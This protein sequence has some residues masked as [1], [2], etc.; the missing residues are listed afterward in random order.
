MAEPIDKFDLPRKDWY[1]SEGRI[2]KDA[3]IENFNAIEDELLSISQLDVFVAELP[4]FSKISYPDVTLEDNDNKVINL[5][6]F[7]EIT[8]LMNYPIECVFNGTTCERIAW[9]GEDYK[10]HVVE[11]DGTAAK[12]STPFIY[13][14]PNPSDGN[15][16]FA[17][18]NSTTPTGCHFIGFYDN[19]RV[20]TNSTP[21]PMNLNVLEGLSQMST[22]AKTTQTGIMDSKANG[23]QLPWATTNIPN[24]LGW[25][26][27][28][29]KNKGSQTVN[30]T[31]FGQE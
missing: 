6:S 16:V 15:H 9:W 24:A 17:Q 10:Y 22:V 27:Y 14:N 18:A 8:G 4:D 12:A 13:F 26:Y 5:K 31:E 23:G 21:I 3:L 7:L 20:V 29:E 1:D 25:H 28:Q 19:G 30:L 2:Y 11:N